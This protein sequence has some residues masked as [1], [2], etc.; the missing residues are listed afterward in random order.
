MEQFAEFQGPSANDYVNVRALNTAFLKTISTLNGNQQERLAAAPL[1][2]FSV[3]EGDL[4]WWDRLLAGSW[5]VDLMDDPDLADPLRRQLQF[6]ALSFLWHL[7]RRNAYAARVITGASV[8]WCERIGALPLVTLLHRAGARADLIRSR[9]DVAGTLSDHL[10]LGARSRRN[11]V[12]R[13]SQYTALQV[14]LTSNDAARVTAMA[15]AACDMAGPVRALNKK[16]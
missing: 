5:Q 3:H 13:S 7:S 16:V 8:A 6:A 4:P 15:S 11:K 12:R 9:L 1:L 2:L 10:L 14:L